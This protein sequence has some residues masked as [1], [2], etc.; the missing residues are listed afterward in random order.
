MYDV[1][2]PHCIGCRQMRPDVHTYFSVGQMLDNTAMIHRARQ[3]E[4]T[5][6]L[7]LRTKEKF[8]SKIAAYHGMLMWSVSCVESPL[9]LSEKLKCTRFNDFCRTQLYLYLTVCVYL[10]LVRQTCKFIR[11][12]Y[13][14]QVYRHHS[15][16]IKPQKDVFYFYLQYIRPILFPTTGYPGIVR[17]FE[18]S[19]ANTVHTFMCTYILYRV[20]LYTRTC[21]PMTGCAGWPHRTRYSTCWI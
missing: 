1:V 19:L 9:L 10:L 2:V 13:P 5:V 8:A 21:W 18:W 7:A 16:R 15:T 6:E 17:V 12:Q 20:P 14:V 4:C 11:M 3:G